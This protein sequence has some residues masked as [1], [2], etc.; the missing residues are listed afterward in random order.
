[1]KYKGLIAMGLGVILLV[2]ALGLFLYNHNLE[3][4]AEE[5]SKDVVPRL[6][7]VIENNKSSIAKNPTSDIQEIEPLEIGQYQYAGILS[8]PSLELQLPVLDYYD[9]K[10]LKKSPCRYS[11]DTSGHMVI[12]A[13]N[14]KSHFG[15]LSK[16]T[17][18][19]AIYYTNNI[20][21]VFEY[22]VE[23]IE[24]L[25]GDDK[26]LLLNEEWDLSLFTCN[27]LGDKRITVR[28]KKV[29]I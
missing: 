27:Y 18:G 5:T 25:D 17:N 2:A 28:C 26:E 14:Y 9:Y 1:M 16:L 24:E 22:R 4:A 8:I 12:A 23:L 6:Q 21:D 19:D 15:N 3:N 7:K 13:H 10:E 11:G 29:N 20:G